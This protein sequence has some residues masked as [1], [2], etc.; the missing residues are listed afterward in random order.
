M[1]LYLL[2]FSFFQY[3]LSFA[4]NV[5]CDLSKVTNEIF[6]TKSFVTKFLSQRPIKNTYFSS[7][8]RGT[9]TRG[10]K[11]CVSITMKLDII[12]RIPNIN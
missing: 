8:V 5:S 1:N 9:L 2:T 7:N 11:E 12:P 10:P 6:V 3:P 4:T